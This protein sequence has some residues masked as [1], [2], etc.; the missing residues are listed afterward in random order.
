MRKT[1]FIKFGLLNG[2]NQNGFPALSRINDPGCP[3]AAASEKAYG[4]RNIN[5]EDVPGSY[6]LIATFIGCR[7]GSLTKLQTCGDS[8]IGFGVV[9]PVFDG[10]GT[11]PHAESRTRR[12]AATAANEHGSHRDRQEEA[13]FGEEPLVRH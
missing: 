10:Y 8:V 2:R 3:Y 4:A 6:V 13:D 5:P 12:S 1:V 11:V 7:F 9:S